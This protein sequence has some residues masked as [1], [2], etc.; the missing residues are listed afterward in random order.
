MKVKR[1]FIRSFSATER[2]TVGAAWRRN[3]AKLA[4]ALVAAGVVK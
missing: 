2:R 4:V 1:P 3:L